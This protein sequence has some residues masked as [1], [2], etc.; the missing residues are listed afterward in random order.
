MR[1]ARNALLIL[2]VCLALHYFN[3]VDFRQLVELDPSVVLDTLLPCTLFLLVVNALAAIRWVLIVNRFL[4]S[5]I[6]FMAGLALTFKSGLFAYFLP[7]QLGS[8]LGRVI[9]ASRGRSPTDLNHAISASIIDRVI[10]LISMLLM[11][12]MFL[13][14]AFL[15]RY[16]AVDVAVTLGGSFILA[17][18]LVP[19]GTKVLRSV[20]FALKKNRYIDYGGNILKMIKTFVIEQPVYCILLLLY[21]MLLNLAVAY[22]IYLIV[23]RII[24]PMDFSTVALMSLVS[25]LSA[26]IPITPGGVGI[27]EMVFRETGALVQGLSVE[28]LAGGYI[29]FRLL[30]ISSYIFGMLLLGLA[31][32]VLQSRKR[33]I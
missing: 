28:N 17:V 6:D 16:D 33:K 15:S 25:N 12:A 14:W 13:A 23:S 27:S 18:A 19:L 1:Y 20:V 5:G 32:L 24:H 2:V 11:A 30:N 8:E 22:V 3:I 31:R 29:M 4:G 7:G 21:S 9:L 26:V 10:A